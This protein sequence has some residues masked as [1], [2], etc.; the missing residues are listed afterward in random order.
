MKEMSEG[1]MKG[2]MGYTDEAVVSSDF[3]HSAYSC[4]FDAK[5]GVA[6]NS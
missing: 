1:E 3:N 5:A 4:V 6:L 2:I